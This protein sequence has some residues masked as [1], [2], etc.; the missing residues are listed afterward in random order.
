[1][2][3][4]ADEYP[5]SELLEAF[6]GAD[7]VVNTVGTEQVSETVSHSFV[8]AA[9]EAGVKRF[10]PSE[11]GLNN[12]LGRAKILGGLFMGKAKLLAYLRSKEETGLTWTGLATGSLIDW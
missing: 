11:Y 4:I 12:S 8:D 5:Y 1:M 3:R 10:M 7:A 2:H 6:Q 9:I